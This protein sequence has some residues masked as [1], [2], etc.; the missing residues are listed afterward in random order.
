MLVH[1]TSIKHCRRV[2]SCIVLLIQSS[3]R[4]RSNYVF[5]SY[6]RVFL[7]DGGGGNGGNRVMQSLRQTDVLNR[8][9]LIG[10]SYDTILDGVSHEMHCSV[11]L[12]WC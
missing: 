4:R 6:S 3:I 9:S 11:E 1:D 12:H 2:D 10:S 5:R 8:E 7:Y